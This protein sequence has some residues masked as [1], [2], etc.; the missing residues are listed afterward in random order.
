MGK[1]D[2]PDIEYRLFDHIKYIDGFVEKMNLKD[3]AFVVHDWG[4][5]LDFYWN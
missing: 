2:K 4:F 5:V 1:S 3:I